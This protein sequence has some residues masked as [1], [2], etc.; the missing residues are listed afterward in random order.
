MKTKE[1]FKKDGQTNLFRFFILLFLLISLM[2]ASKVDN[3]NFYAL[4]LFPFCLCCFLWL[5]TTTDLRKRIQMAVIFT[6]VAFCFW[7]NFTLAG[8]VTPI[9]GGACILILWEVI[10][11]LKLKR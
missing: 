2:K 9:A 11:R 5:V 4:L 1:F 6:L 3:Y 8:I 10:N 7:G